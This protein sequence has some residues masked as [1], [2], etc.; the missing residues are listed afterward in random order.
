MR[1]VS[2]G[3]GWGK[4]HDLAYWF[5]TEIIGRDWVAADRMGVHV[6]HASKLLKMGYDI[7]DIQACVMN[8]VEGTFDFD[9]PD[10]FLERPMRYLSVVTQGEPPYIEQFL[11]PPDP[12]AVYEIAAY[13]EWIRRHGKKAI[14]CGAWD[15]IYWPINQPH[16]LTEDDIALILGEEHAQRSLERVGG[17]RTSP[18][19]HQRGQSG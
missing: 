15:G 5:I 10:G 14:E 7:Q 1:K 16:R 17:C 11:R 4:P 18:I 9:A 2:K 6:T 12:P 13:D 8:M 19:L 3:K